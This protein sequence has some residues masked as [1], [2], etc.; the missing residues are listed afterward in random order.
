MGD[1]QK[2]QV[3]VQLEYRLSEVNWYEIHKRT[4]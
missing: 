2:I 3:V 4:V 1:I